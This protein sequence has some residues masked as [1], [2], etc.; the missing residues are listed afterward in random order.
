MKIHT[1]AWDNTDQRMIDSHKMVSDHFGLDVVYTFENIPHGQWMNDVMASCDEDVVGF[2]DIDC[3]PTNRDIVDASYRYAL[4]NESFVGI[5]QSTNHIRPGA[6]IFAAPAFFFI[7]KKTWLRLGRPTFDQTRNADIAE[8]VSY[9]AEQAG[10]TYKAL[11]PTHYERASTEGVW[12]L[13]NYGCYGIGT[14]FA[15]G[16]F[17]LYQG[18]LAL[19]IERF[20]QRCGDVV[21]NKFSL[22]DA[23]DCARWEIDAPLRTPFNMPGAHHK[24]GPKPLRIQSVSGR[25]L[26]GLDETRPPLPV[27]RPVAEAFLRLGNALRSDTLCGAGEWIWK[28]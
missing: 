22:D 26:F 13:G 28:I 8:N 20:V 6:H 2:L 15:G 18:R 11:Y 5:A 24:K 25:R 19:N 16:V 4:N 3:I 27:L 23:L 21:A 9:A 17:H 1:L 10:L 7:S 12:R 14:H